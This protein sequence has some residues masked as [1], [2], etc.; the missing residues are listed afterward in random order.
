M[1]S[2][3]EIQECKRCGTCCQ[4]G[5]PALH[6]ADKVLVDEGVLPANG[7]YTLRRGE[8]AEDSLSGTLVTL[9]FELIKVKG[10]Q[11]TRGCLF[12]DAPQGS[13]RIYDNRPLECRL[14]KCWDTQ[15][16]ERVYSDRRLVRHDVLKGFE[17][18]WDIIADHE[19]RCS[20]DTL[21]NLVRQLQ[22]SDRDAAVN[23]IVEIVRYDTEIRKL[24]SEKGGLDPGLNDFLLGRPLTETIRMFGL[25]V[26]ETE[27]K[28]IVTKQGW[29]YTSSSEVNQTMA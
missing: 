29:D 10:L 8:L 11:E 22:H 24:V 20:Y 4:K 19:N 12:Y 7:L 21:K 14:L 28:C 15:D 3:P 1:T 23:M 25:R 13:C 26:Q 17:G 5:G 9:T 27:G 2:P 18:M 16:L 6:Q